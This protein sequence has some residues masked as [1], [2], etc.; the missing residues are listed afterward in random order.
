MGFFL[1]SFPLLG[2]WSWEGGREGCNQPSPGPVPGPVPGPGPVAGRRERGRAPCEGSQRHL[3]AARGDRRPRAR[4][5]RGA[6]AGRAP[7]PP[8]RVS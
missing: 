8:A 5:G 1:V 3:V 6:R 4:A 7:L 2:A